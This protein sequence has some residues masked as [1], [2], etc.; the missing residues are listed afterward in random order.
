MNS[1]ANNPRLSDKPPVTHSLWL[2]VALR[3]GFL[4]LLLGG[5]QLL[6]MFGPGP[7]YLRPGPADVVRSFGEIIAN[8]TLVESVLTSMGRMA[9]GFGTSAVVG[10]LLGIA[11]D[12]P[13]AGLVLGIL[14]AFLVNNLKAGKHPGMARHL[15]YWFTGFPCPSELPGSHIREMN[16]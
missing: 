12:M 9:I 13:L 4:L 7:V 3:V 5:W 2:V 15:L 10:M 1:L 14:M 6:A 11:S 8:K 16:G